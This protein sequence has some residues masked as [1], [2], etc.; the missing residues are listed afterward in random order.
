[1]VHSIAHLARAC[2][3]ACL[4]LYQLLPHVGADCL[5]HRP[6]LLVAGDVA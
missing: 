1:M 4:A 5:E 6:H 2:P 3:L